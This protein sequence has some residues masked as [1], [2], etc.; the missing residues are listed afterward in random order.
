M[1]G[2]LIRVDRP[3]CHTSV[4][5]VGFPDR[6]ACPLATG[7]PDEAAAG[8]GAMSQDAR[9]APARSFQ[10]AGATASGAGPQASGTCCGWR[11]ATEPGTT[12]WSQAPIAGDLQFAHGQDVACSA[13]RDDR[14][15]AGAQIMNVFMHM[16]KRIGADFEKGLAQLASL[17]IE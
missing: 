10:G 1:P 11:A 8:S 12:W 7:H 16:D 2:A 6:S 15:R 17:A 3:A 5:I 9:L 4:E 13:Q 14:C